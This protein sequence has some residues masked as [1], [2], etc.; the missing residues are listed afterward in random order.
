MNIS[1]ESY[2]HAVIL[3]LKGDLTEDA[4]A[5]LRQAVEHQLEN[6]EV[7]DLVINLE[8]VPFID[9]MALE[10]LLELQDRLA[11]KFGRVKL[12]KVD[13]NVLTILEMTRLRSRF[14]IFRDIP[15]AVKAMQ[16]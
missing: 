13:D 9:S 2:G 8:E 16:P 11:E 10:Y 7:V 5:A 1:A 4:L 3:N 6:A 14:E 12:A 15:E